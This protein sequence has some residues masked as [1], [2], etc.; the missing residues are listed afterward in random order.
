MQGFSERASQIA[1]ESD[2]AVQVLLSTGNDDIELVPLKPRAFPGGYITPS[3]FTSRRLRSVGVVGVDAGGFSS[4]CAFKE[5][6]PDFLVARI[7]EAFGEYARV[8]LG[9]NLPPQTE[10]EQI[11]ELERI[12]RLEDPRPN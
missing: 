4:A 6:L 3:E 9:D 12:F 1:C 7:A 10:A 5:D 8:L 11:A 2:I